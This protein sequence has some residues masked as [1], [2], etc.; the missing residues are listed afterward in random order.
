[1]NDLLGNA[2]P[3]KMKKRDAYIF[4]T[5]PNRK[6][7]FH[8]DRECNFLMQIRGDKVIHLF[9]K[10]DRDVLPEEEIE[11]F[12]TVDNN[13]AVY[14]PEY[15]DR[16]TSYN[17]TPGTGVHIPVNAPHWVQNGNNI[18]VTLALTFQFMTTELANIYR[19]NFYLRKMG[20]TP[21]PPGQSKVRDSVKAR[22]FAAAAAVRRAVNS[23]RGKR[24][25]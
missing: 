12:W 20:I 4:I 5:S 14:K 8:I 22:S 25:C 19:T 6:T 2:L 17:F 18:S 13:A 21:L 23:I 10:Y 1:M 9:S 3:A 7:V 16:A 15:Q 11:R 24:D